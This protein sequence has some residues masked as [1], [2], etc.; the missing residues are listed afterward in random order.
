MQSEA[1]ND[2]EYFGDFGLSRGGL[3]RLF[4]DLFWGTMGLNSDTGRQGEKNRGRR[5]GNNSKNSQ[6]AGGKRKK[7]KVP[8]PF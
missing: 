7:S 4:S 8:P 2:F 5:K 6:S 1:T 3:C